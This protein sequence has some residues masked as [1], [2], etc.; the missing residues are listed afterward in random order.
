MRANKPSERVFSLALTQRRRAMHLSWRTHWRAKPGAC[1]SRTHTHAGARASARVLHAHTRARLRAHARTKCIRENVSV[2]G[3]TMQLR[4][5]VRACVCRC[6]CTGVSAPA[7]RGD[8]RPG[9]TRKRS[10]LTSP[11]DRRRC[12]PSSPSSLRAVCPLGPLSSHRTLP[13]KSRGRIRRAYSPRARR[14]R[15][16]RTQVLVSPV[17]IS[18]WWPFC[19]CRSANSFWGPEDFLRTVTYTNRI[20]SFH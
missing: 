13:A 18:A 6:M 2:H 3:C 7:Q 1:R 16:W 4:A 12:T 9:P 5:R 10:T 11:N 20:R 19:C 15:R 17:E 14:L 8:R